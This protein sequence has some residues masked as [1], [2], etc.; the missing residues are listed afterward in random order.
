MDRLVH[1]RIFRSQAG[2]GQHPDGAADHGSFVRQNVA[3]QVG[4]DDYVELAGISHQLHCAVI[5]IHVAECDIGVIRL[6][7][8]GHRFAPQAGG[9]EHVGLV[10][11]A[12][13][14]V[15]LASHIEADAGNALDFGYAVHLRI[16]GR[17]CPVHLLC[18]ALAEIDAAGQLAHDHQIKRGADDVGADGRSA[19]QRLKNDGG[20]QVREQPERLANAQKP[21]FGPLAAGQHIPLGA[22][23]RAEQD[24]VRRLAG[25]Y[26]L[27]RQ[28]GP[29]RVDRAAAQQRGGIFH[30]KAEFFGGAAEHPLCLLYNFRPDS[31]PFEYGDPIFLHLC[32]SLKQSVSFMA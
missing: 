29:R 11:A 21:C 8:A 15:S 32:S 25:I 22:A 4:G 30:G 23:H 14:A 24:C 10:D 5:H 31:V 7:D 9:I 3:E 13:A 16:V 26:G 2:G 12:Q 17:L 28:G 19:A 27:L 18:A 1:A 6:P 20:A